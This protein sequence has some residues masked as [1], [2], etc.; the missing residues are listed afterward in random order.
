[1][2]K[3]D[4]IAIEEATLVLKAI[5]DRAFDSPEFARQISN[6]PVPG[7]KPIQHFLHALSAT[8]SR[9]TGLLHGGA[10]PK[11]RKR[12]EKFGQFPRLP[13]MN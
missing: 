5:A 8:S 6:L 9:P 3:P 7:G 2:T 13:R 1:M 12:L 4:R 11:P 10:I